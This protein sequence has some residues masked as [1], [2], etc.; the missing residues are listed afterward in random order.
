LL[1]DVNCQNRDGKVTNTYMSLAKN[2]GGRVE[3]KENFLKI[4]LQICE[5]L[6]RS[7]KFS[8]KM[9]FFGQKSQKFLQKSIIL[10]RGRVA[11]IKNFIGGRGYFKPPPSH[12]PTP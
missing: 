3:V 12:P 4:L 8:E 2:F 11:F 6:E 10:G 9:T 1:E 7:Q 5:N